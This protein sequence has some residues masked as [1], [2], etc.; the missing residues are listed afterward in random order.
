MLHLLPWAPAGSR[1]RATQFAISMPACPTLGVPGA[2]LRRV[3]RCL[4]RF[5]TAANNVCT[6]AADA[7]DAFAHANPS[8]SVARALFSCAAVC[9][10]WP[11]TLAAGDSAWGQQSGSA[12]E[13][14]FN[15]GAELTVT[16]H[17]SSGEPM[18][19]TAMVQVYRNG[20]TP[21]GQAATSQGR[22]V[23]VLTP[24]GSF[25][26]MVEAA[27]YQRAQKDV[28]LPTAQRAQVDIYLRREVIGGASPGVGGATPAVPGKPLLAP[29]AKEALDKGL[30][31]LSADKLGNAEKYVGEA[32]RLAPSHPD[33][34]YVRGVLYLKEQ[35]WPQAQEVLRKA[36]Q[37]DPG[38]AR[39]FAALGM[40][41]LDGGK[42]DAGIAPLEKALQLDA[43]VG[44]EAQWTLAKAY[45]QRERYDQALKMS[46]AA[47]QA[48]K[49]KAPQIALLVAQSL[50]AVGRYDDAA[51]ELREFVT[52]HG[53]RPEAVTARRWLQKLQ[54][55]DVEARKQ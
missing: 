31:A 22:A 19:S 46:Q 10:Y 4:A 16:V 13:A 33:V 14:R 21:A 29:K 15:N 23:F 18:T 41:L 42:Y 40:A 26:V 45:Y 1:S 27:G 17:D 44:W 52:E 48:S 2:S 55:R 51:A 50:T 49:G 37:V 34:L 53:D 36:T 12:A 32:T 8:R 54:A 9:A 24:L 20:V 35:N 3:A 28:A 30:Q 25:T 43:A 39:A 5:A 6:K 7:R 47:L 11:G 38:H